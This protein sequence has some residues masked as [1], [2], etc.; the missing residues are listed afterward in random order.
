MKLTF[1]KLYGEIVAL[2]TYCA[3]GNVEYLSSTECA[4]RFKNILETI[5]EYKN[6][7]EELDIDSIT[8]FKALKDGVYVISYDEGMV[9]E[10]PMLGFNQERGTN[11]YIL[12]GVCHMPPDELCK[13]S[14]YYLKDYG[15][16]WAL[17][18]EELIDEKEN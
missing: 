12:D 7:E 14:N 16:T 8:L 3:T 2:M 18:R 5:K 10:E 6:I 15:K 13:S 11:L 9:F 4:N 17:T 1:D